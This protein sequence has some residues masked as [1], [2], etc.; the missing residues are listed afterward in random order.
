M[1]TV[2]RLV[3][4]IVTARA[5]VTVTMIVGHMQGAGGGV[6]WLQWWLQ[7]FAVQWATHGYRG[8]E[9][10]PSVVGVQGRC[11]WRRWCSLVISRAV[12]WVV[13]L[14]VLLVVLLVGLQLVW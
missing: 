3:T 6:Q 8:N 2:I 11:R 7:R 9:P 14:A 10:A 5:T 12:L 1:L 4:V 13:L